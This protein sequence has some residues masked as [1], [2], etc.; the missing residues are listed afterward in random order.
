MKDAF[1][2]LKQGMKIKIVHKND[3]TQPEIIATHNAVSLVN[4][5]IN[6]IYTKDECIERFYSTSSFKF[7]RKI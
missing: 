5:V 2:I 6:G 1:D 4:G 7:E 3:I